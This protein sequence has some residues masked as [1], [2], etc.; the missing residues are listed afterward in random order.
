MAGSEALMAS[1][2]SSF[3]LSRPKATPKR[4]LSVREAQT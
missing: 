4:G 3:W 2:R 1:S